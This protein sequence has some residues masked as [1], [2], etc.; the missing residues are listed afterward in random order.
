MRSVSVR[1]SFPLYFKDSKYQWL[2]RNIG[3]KCGR[4]FGI[5]RLD[6]K[7]KLF[8]ICISASCIKT[9]INLK[10]Y[11]HTSFLYLKKFYG[12][13]CHLHK[14]YWSTKK[15]FEKKI[16]SYFCFRLIQDRDGKLK[17]VHFG[18]K[19]PLEVFAGG[20]KLY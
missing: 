8:A 14:T 20:M 16:L 11:C 7:I 2:K 6:I 9:K 19:Q 3:R 15:K 4:F 10:F 18:E 13:L 5:K 17:K 12:G 1:N